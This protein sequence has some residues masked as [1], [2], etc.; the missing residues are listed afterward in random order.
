MKTSIFIDQEE[1]I[2]GAC[3]GI[4]VRIQ[5]KSRRGRTRRKE[6]KEDDTFCNEQTQERLW[7][8]GF[9]GSPPFL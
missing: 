9:V 4:M 2:I 3:A 6:E 8:G 7:D 1:E 5:L